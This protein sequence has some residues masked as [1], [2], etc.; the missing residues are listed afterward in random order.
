MYININRYKEWCRR[1]ETQSQGS[2]G[3]CMSLVQQ[4]NAN[5]PQ[6]SSLN[7]ASIKFGTDIL[8]GPLFHKKGINHAKIQDGCHFSKMAAIHWPIASFSRI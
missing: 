7:H 1:V 6:K 8:K 2:N 3:P 4:I 5:I